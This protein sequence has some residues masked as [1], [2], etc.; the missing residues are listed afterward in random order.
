[1]TVADLIAELQG[2]PQDL[3][4]YVEEGSRARNVEPRVSV[5]DDRYRVDVGDQQVVIL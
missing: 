1:M 2:M 5:V 4:V 3:D